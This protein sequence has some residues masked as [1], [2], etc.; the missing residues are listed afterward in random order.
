MQY[1]RGVSYI[2]PT[3]LKDG[4]PE[5]MAMQLLFDPDAIMGIVPAQS[6]QLFME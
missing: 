2:I 3:K 5:G 4:K 1:F 6:E